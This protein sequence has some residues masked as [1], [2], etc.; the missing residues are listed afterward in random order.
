MVWTTAFLP[1]EIAAWSSGEYERALAALNEPAE[2]KRVAEE[3]WFTT[4]LNAGARPELGGFAWEVEFPDVFFDEHGRL[5]NG[6]FDAVIGNPPYDVL[7]EA[8]SGRDL[9]ALRKYIDF[10]P[11]YKPSQRGKNN[12]YK[13]FICRALALLADGGYFGF[14]TPMAVLGDDSAADLRRAML[15]AGR[16]TSIDAFPQKDDPRR[17][18]FP[19][20]KL[21]TAVFVMQKRRDERARTATFTS[22]VHPGRELTEVQ[23]QLQLSSDE[24]PL[25]DPSNLTIVSCD[26]ADWN[27]ATRIMRTGRLVRLREYTQFFQGEVNETNERANGTISYD[28][29]AGQRVIRGAGICLYVLRPASQGKEFFVTRELFLAGRDSESKAFHH[30]HARVGVQE[31]CPQNSF[32]RVIAAFI[33]AGEFCNH[34][35]NYCP[36]HR[37]SFDLRLLLGLLNSK[38]TDWY[39]RLGSTNAAVSHYQLYNLPCPVFA[40]IAGEDGRSK[41]RVLRQIEDGE[42]DA[43][44]VSLRPL[45]ATAPFDLAIRNAIVCAV[46]CIIGKEERRGEIARSD[47]SALD[48]SAQKHQ[49]F[50][51]TLLFAMAGLSADEIAG[52]DE[53]LR[54]ML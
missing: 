29:S 17:R 6:G 43:A 16:F 23:A 9:S 46:D 28:E 8:E 2:F 27:L 52:L 54:Q 26:Q 14:I 48:S 21:S 35:I 38:L 3:P 15:G 51:D 39:F 10:E 31:S 11:V 41:D 34:K 25:Y 49:D 45:T 24:I 50:I 18:V 13:L 12:L 44:F 40:D 42:H 22:R 20:A 36:A 19:E 32:R 33:P 53:R 4:A 5:E 7:S 47:R 1:R 30:F 37:C